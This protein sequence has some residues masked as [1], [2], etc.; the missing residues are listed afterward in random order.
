MSLRS[1]GSLVNGLGILRSVLEEARI[2]LD[3]TLGDLT[4]LSAAVDPYRLDTPANHRAGEWVAKQLSRF[5]KSGKRIHWRGLHYVIS[6]KAPRKPDGVIFRNTDEDWTWLADVA[7]KAARWLGYIP[8]DRITDNRN[9][10]PIIHRKARVNPQAFVS[11]GLNVTIP[12]VE[13]LQPTPYA[14][15]FVA[16]QAYSFAIFGEKA[17][18][19][20]VVLPIARAHQADLYLMTGEISDTYVYHIAKDAVADGRPLVVF[21]LAD[22]DP[23]GWQMAVS[24]GRKLQALRDFSFPELQFELV[25]VALTIDQVRDLG[26]PST[27][28]KETEKRADRWREAFGVEQTEIDALATLQPDALREIIERSFDAY[29]DRGLKARV[30]QAEAVWQRQAEA[31]IRAQIDPKIL[32]QLGQ[33]AGERLAELESMISD[34]NAKLR[35]AAD[36]FVLPAIEVPEPEL[37]TDAVRRALITFDQSWIEATRALI[38]R[39]AYEGSAS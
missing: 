38:R 28:L 7:G 30:A 21:I 25:P 9:T 15:G 33:E 13:D 3:C 10:P 26:L 19:E 14:E 22:C 31:A 23:A 20:D 6:T 12:D 1:A 36:R 17:S 8:F 4:V 16:T 39:K 18:L 11:V 35:L 24:I 32:A 29:I 37:D 5:V 2:E 27:P 34:I